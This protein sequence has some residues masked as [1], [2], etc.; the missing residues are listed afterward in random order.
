MGLDLCISVYL[1]Y[2]IR[3]LLNE[4]SSSSLPIPLVPGGLNVES[5]ET[6]H[7]N[8]PGLSAFNSGLIYSC[9]YFL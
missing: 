4:L 3:Q 9:T 7:P 2:N 8:S 5:S 1:V 6:K